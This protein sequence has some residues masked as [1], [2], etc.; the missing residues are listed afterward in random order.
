[1]DR[2]ENVRELFAKKKWNRDGS[3]FYHRQIFANGY[4]YIYE[5]DHDETFEHPWYEVFKRKV[6]EDIE[7]VDGQFIRS[8]TNGHVKYPCNEDFGKTAKCCSTI[9]D[10]EEWIMKWTPTGQDYV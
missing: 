3:T 2:F 10:A 8:K 9:K 5:V 4:A 7:K 6:V 1:M